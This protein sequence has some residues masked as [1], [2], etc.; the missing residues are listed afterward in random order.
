M[1]EESLVWIR[2]TSPPPEGKSWGMGSGRGRALP[3]SHCVTLGTASHS[4]GPRLPTH[5]RAE[6]GAPM[7]AGLGGRLSSE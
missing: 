5:T 3:R 6:A 4:L 1:R 7:P 2:T